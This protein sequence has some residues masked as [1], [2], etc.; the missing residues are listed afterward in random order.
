MGELGAP[1]D[2]GYLRGPLDP[3]FDPYDAPEMVRERVMQQAAG[4][5]LPEFNG[6][7]FMC[8]IKGGRITMGGDMEITLVIP[9][10]EKYRALPLTDA[11]GMTVQINAQRKRRVSVTDYLFGR[12]QEIHDEYDP[13]PTLAERHQ[14]HYRTCDCL[15]NSSE[16]C[17]PK[18]C[19]QDQV[20]EDPIGDDPP[21]DEH[22]HE[23]E[24]PSVDVVDSGDMESDVSDEPSDPVVDQGTDGPGPDD[25]D[26]LGEDREP[27]PRGVDLS[28]LLRD[29]QRASD[30]NDHRDPPS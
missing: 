15:G 5:A 11:V 18:C 13:E 26:D 24:V 16:C 10:N 2:S 27:G 14:E 29:L 4:Q 23:P 7:S 12:N 1:G 9:P 19:P 17:D 30:E 25:P 22:V 6:A 20:I 8:S 28:R 21:P 3:D